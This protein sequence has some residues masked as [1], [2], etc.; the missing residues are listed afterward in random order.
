MNQLSFL[1]DVIIS[2]RVYFNSKCWFV[3][4]TECGITCTMFCSWVLNANDVFKDIKI[5]VCVVCKDCSVIFVIK[6]IIMELE[7]NV[8]ELFKI[9]C[10]WRSE[11]PRL[12]LKIMIYFL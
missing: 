6:G 3:S 10:I 4:L 5:N 9:V 12:A 8:C 1:A 11:N 2:I 7:K